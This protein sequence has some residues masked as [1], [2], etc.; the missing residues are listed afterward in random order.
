VFVTKPIASMVRHASLIGRL[1][2][3]FLFFLFFCPEP[4]QPDADEFLPAASSRVTT[5]KFAK[6]PAPL[7]GEKAI[8]AKMTLA[9]G[10]VRFTAAFQRI[11][12]LVNRFQS[13]QG[14]YFVGNRLA[15][16]PPQ[17]LS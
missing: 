1:A 5:I 11:F 14:F 6:A 12:V 7:K 2:I 4:I 17:M 9:I 3:L 13:F 16:S 8:S 10:G 15:R